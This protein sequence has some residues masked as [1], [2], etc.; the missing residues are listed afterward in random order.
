[1]LDKKVSLYLSG[2]ARL[3]YFDASY[4]FYL[5]V[6]LNI[7]AYIIAFRKTIFRLFHLNY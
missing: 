5:T 3:S 1:M 2:K 7:K 6:S 4:F